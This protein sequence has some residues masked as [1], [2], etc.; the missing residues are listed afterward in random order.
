[1]AATMGSETTA[2]ATGKIG[3]V[4]RDPFAMFPFVGYHMGDYFGHWL[5]MGHGLPRPPKIFRGQL[6]PQGR[7]RQVRVARLR[8]EHAGAEV[9]RRALRRAAPEVATPIGLMPEYDDLNW[10]GLDFGPD[11]YAQV[12]EI[13]ADQW[14]RELESHKELFAKIG[15]KRPKELLREFDRLSSHLLV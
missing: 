4:R 12:T 6:V 2:A 8:R 11:R 5:E 13:V 1:M 7:E 15:A 14:V 9:D 3:D 10:E